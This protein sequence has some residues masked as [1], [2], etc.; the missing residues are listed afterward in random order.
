MVRSSVGG[1]SCSLA[2]GGVMNVTFTAKAPYRVNDSYQFAATANSGTAPVY[3]TWTNDANVNIALSASINVT[4]DPSADVN[5]GTN[6]TP[7]CVGC[8]FGP[9][10]IN[11]G[12]VAD[13]STFNADGHGERHR[14][15]RR[16]QSA[17]LGSLRVDR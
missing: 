11:V 8:T 12:S 10:F 6:P 4:T 3:P 7:N 17:R 2:P 1:S 5:A 16:V 9:S 15:H 13:G 14:E